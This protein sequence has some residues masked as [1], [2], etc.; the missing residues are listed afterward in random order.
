[1]IV[2]MVS[3][4]IASFEIKRIAGILYHLEGKVST[5]EVKVSNLYKNLED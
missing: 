2:V 1:M 4:V 5:L 3:C